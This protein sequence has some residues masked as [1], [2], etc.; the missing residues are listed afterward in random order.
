M[1]ADIFKCGYWAFPVVQW[2]G[3]CTFTA[4]GLS[5]IPSWG[6]KIIQSVW[7]D[8]LVPP[9]PPPHP[10]HHSIIKLFGYC[11]DRAL[12]SE[13]TMSSFYPKKL[14]GSTGCIMFRNP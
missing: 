6:T 13:D 11:Y 9:K 5:S 2:L 14:E 7:C 8:S 10:R 1:K 4:E 12:G 3:L